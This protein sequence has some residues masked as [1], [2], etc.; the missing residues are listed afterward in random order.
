MTKTVL[1]IPGDGIGQEVIPAAVRVLQALLPSVRVNWAQ[2]G[3]ETFV[4]TG[5]ALPSEVLAQA[6]AADAVL[7]GAT[8][9]P[10][11]RVEGYTSP[12]LEFRQR[13]RLCANL[14]PVRTWP[15]IRALH[16]EIDL[17]IVRENCEG[18]YIR[19]EQRE[20]EIA[21]ATR[22]VTQK[23]SRRVAE[24]AFQQAAHRARARGRVSKVTIIHKANVL[25]V[26]DGLFR[27]VAL[28]VA[29]AYPHIATEERLVDAAAMLLVQ[30]PQQFDVLLAPNLYGDILSDE[31]A[32]LAGGLGL[33][34]SAN[35]GEGTPVF[36]PVHGAAPDI[37]G[38]GIANPMAAMLSVALMLETWGYPALAQRLQDA[39]AQ[40]LL[41]G[42]V[43]PDLGGAATTEEFTQHV[44]QRL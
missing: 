28:E 29:R 26:T 7:F 22:R 36:E 4:E 30:S 8:A 27:E 15:A 20:G 41:T 3:W 11:G 5:R 6:R 9:S 14:R 23:G 35:I 1:A 42:R 16:N 44:L 37:A 13:F 33:A 38:Q 34:P 2:A 12:I 31:A 17:L 25:N 21:W 19:E 10:S 43:T 32:G 24:V 39:L 40:V 18:L